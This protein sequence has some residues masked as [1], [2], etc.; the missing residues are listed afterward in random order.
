MSTVDPRRFVIAAAPSATTWIE[1]AFRRAFG[2]PERPPDE[3]TRLVERL[4][5][6]P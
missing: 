3:L 4:R 6:A 2:A 5:Q 1:A